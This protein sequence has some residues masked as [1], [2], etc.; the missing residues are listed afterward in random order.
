M[1][2]FSGDISKSGIQSL[3]I[4]FPDKVWSGHNFHE[5]GY[6]GI[7]FSNKA[8]NGWVRNVTITGSDIGIWIDG[9]S[10]HITVEKWKLDLGSIRAAGIAGQ[11]HHGVNIYGGYNL[12]QEFE[13][14]GKFAHDLSVESS[15]S[16]FNVIRNG[17]GKDICIDHHNHNS[18]NNLFTNLDLGIGSRLYLS[19]G[20]DRPLGLN[21]NETYWNITAANYL[22]YNLTGEGAKK[23]KN[24]VAVGI[25]TT[26]ASMLPNTDNNWY[27]TI[28]PS[29]L[30]P[31][32]LYVSQ[33]KLVKNINLN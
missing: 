20:N 23:S 9:S 25:K 22:S 32:D 16:I 24:N 31:K 2:T 13:I 11:G 10:H 29:F 30:F 28:N 18:R 12:F 15:R 21:I 33:M 6:N 7:G 19:G 8:N 3:K 17:K 26:T 4:V 14:E 27:E 1:I 5:R